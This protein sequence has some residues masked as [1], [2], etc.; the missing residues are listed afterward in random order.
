MVGMDV[1]GCNRL[2]ME[3]LTLAVETSGCDSSSE[4][5]LMSDTG[6][7]S[8]WILYESALRLLALLDSLPE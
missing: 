4:Y 3:K 8:S 1:W 5:R 6:G 7:A 2:G